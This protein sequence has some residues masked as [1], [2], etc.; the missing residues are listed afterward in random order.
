MSKIIVVAF[1]LR[2][3]GAKTIYLQFLEHLKDYS[4]RD[5]Y[6]LFVD[7][8]MPQPIIKNVVY[9]P[10]SL[11]GNIRR[12]WFDYMGCSILLKNNKILPDLVISLQNTG[13]YCLKNIP[14]IIYYHQFL[15]LSP[16]QWNP[17]KR[18]QRT[19][20]FYRNIYPLF[21]KNALFSGTQVIVQVPFIKKE[22]VKRY[23]FNQDNVHVLF[24]DIEKID[25]QDI[26]PFNFD[27]K[28]VHFIYPATNQPYKEHVTLVHAMNELKKNDRNIANL[29]QIHLTLDFTESDKLVKLMD[30]LGVR[31]FFK[32]EGIVP[33]EILLSMYRSS[34][35]LLFPSSIET[36][37]LPLLEAARFGLPIIVADLDYAHEVLKNYDGVSFVQCKDYKCWAKLIKNSVLKKMHYSSLVPSKTSDW[38]IFFDIIKNI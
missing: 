20:F 12:L 8:D 34:R 7:T 33:H 30:K 29:V 37:G 16:Q 31:D 4:N 23:R 15:P 22:F 26:V 6:Y 9:F 28:F 13:V 35:A 17:L 25:V 36:L 5:L 19:L 10:V 1:A 32:F 3:S 24:P 14:Q 2:S 11:R 38:D 18:D 21:V 27:D